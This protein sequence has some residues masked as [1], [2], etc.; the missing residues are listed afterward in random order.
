MQN[1]ISRRRALRLL[2]SGAGLTVLAACAPITPTPGGSATRQPASAPASGQPAS[3]PQAEGKPGGTLRLGM[4]KQKQIFAQLN[5]MLLDQTFVTPLAPNPPRVALRSSVKGVTYSA[6]EGFVY[7]GA[8][9]DNA[10]T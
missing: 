7:T 6:H 3:V 10:S 9:L 2:A 5:D 1:E 4:T 8:W